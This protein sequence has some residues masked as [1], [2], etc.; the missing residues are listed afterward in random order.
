M[1]VIV[2]PGVSVASRDRVMELLFGD[3]GRFVR[4]VTISTDASTGGPESRGRSHTAR[5]WPVTRMASRRLYRAAPQLM[6]SSRR[7]AG[8]TGSRPFLVMVNSAP[9]PN[10]AQ[11]SMR[12]SEAFRKYQGWVL[13]TD[14]AR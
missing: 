14:G 8:D 13:W 10:R 12:S 2:W 5:L 7:R 1:T 6:M 3:G 11:M 4:P 9:S